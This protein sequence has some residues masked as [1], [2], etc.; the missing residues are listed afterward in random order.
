[1]HEQKSDWVVTLHQNETRYVIIT[2]ACMLK[3]FLPN[4]G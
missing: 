3:S 2:I 4:R 1:M